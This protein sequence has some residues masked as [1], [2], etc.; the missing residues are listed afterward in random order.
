MDTTELLAI[1][2]AFFAAIEGVLEA[3]GIMKP[4][5]ES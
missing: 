4:K 1:I 2:R 3:L 5:T